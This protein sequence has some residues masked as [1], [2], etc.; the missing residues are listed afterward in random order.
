MIRRLRAR[1]AL[2]VAVA[3]FFVLALPGVAL[4]AEGTVVANTSSSW[5][6]NGTVWS[7]AYANGRIYLAG[8]FTSVRPPGA[9]PGSGEVPRSHMAVLNAA[10]GA[11]L[12]FN[13]TFD[14]RPRALTPSPDGSRI[15]V[16]GN[17]TKIDGVAR[18]RLVA[19]NTATG[20]LVPGW[21]ARPDN[22][23]SSI[24]VSPNGST[25]YLGGTFAHVNSQPRT[26][27]AAVNSAKGGLTSWTPTTDDVTN[28]M[29]VSP[30]GTKVFL[31]G[32]FHQ[33]DGDTT[34][35]KVGALN[36]STGAIVNFP[37]A[38]AM[39]RDSALCSSAAKGVVLSGNTVYFAAEGTGGGCFDGTFAASVSTGS[40]LWKNTCLGATQAIEVVGNYLYKGSHAHDCASQNSYQDPDAFPQVPTNQSRHLLAERL[41]N[42]F[43]GPWYANTNGVPLG[44]RAMAT[45]GTNLWVGGDFTTVNNVAQQ[46]VARFATSPDLT[47]PAKPAAPAAAAGSTG[48]ATITAKAPVDLD[49]PDLIIRLYRDNGT[50]SVAQ[51]AVV[52][53]LFWRQ[54]T[55][56]FTDRGLQRGS[57][58]TWRV[59]A[60]EA[61]GTNTSI[62]SDR[63]VSVTIR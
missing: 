19:F 8:D 3:A 53:S 55:V 38:A 29:V 13:H 5:Q 10:T 44:P 60:I 28:A 2:S 47:K 49:D 32:Y 31:A 48:T 34:Y 57:V 39:P 25:I 63:S 9:A 61:H 46:G 18:T 1:R 6:T 30:D 20:D 11:L 12:P 7:M 41:D 50:T 14:A 21:S 22:T 58:H 35:Q 54:P 59:N 45:D 17:F 42:G 26:R 24:A 37:A 27:L 43:L 33:L 36:A 4:A 15:Y 40:L 16:G 56:T 52:H 23:V 62:L 51:S